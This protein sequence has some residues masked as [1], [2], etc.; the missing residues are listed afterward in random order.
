MRLRSVSRLLVPA[1]WAGAALLSLPV[2]VAHG[3]YPYGGARPAYYPPAY[4]LPQ[5]PYP[6]AM[7]MAPAAA[8]CL[9]YPLLPVRADVARPTA[10]ASFPSSLPAR[11][12]EEPPPPDPPEPTIKTVSASRSAEPS[13]TPEMIHTPPKVMGG[14]DASSAAAPE[15]P[16]PFDLTIGQPPVVTKPDY[17]EDDD[18]SCDPCWMC[19][20]CKKCFP[21]PNDSVVSFIDSAIPR[22]RVRLRYDMAYD[23][24]RPDRAEYLMARFGTITPT[25]TVPPGP[26]NFN[27]VSP[28]ALGPTGPGLPVPVAPLDYQDIR[29]YVEVAYAERFSGYIELPVRFLEADTGLNTAG[30]G[31][32]I[33]GGKFV[34]LRTDKTFA[35]FQFQTYSP[36]GDARRGLGTNHWSIEPGLLWFQRLTDRL[37]FEAELK[38]WIPLDGTEFQGNVLKYGGGLSYLVYSTHALRV[39]PVVE[40]VGWTVLDGFETVVE[41]QLIRVENA[42]WDT[43]VNTSVGVRTSFGRMY[44]RCYSWADVYVGYSRPVTGDFWYKDFFR[45]ELRLNF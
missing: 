7:P 16:N 15:P 5:A 38:D 44:S 20:P 4:Q 11:V 23:V 12:A 1:A 43:I 6:P 37:I 17:C 24:N 13:E 33:A 14:D 41:P 39:Q 34:F 2:C 8:P 26:A 21:V 29:T 9:P 3:Q 36:S 32:V 31:D 25:P 10:P 45:L 22:T 42:S 40:L 35:T 19:Q 28:V 18:A 30:I 27:A